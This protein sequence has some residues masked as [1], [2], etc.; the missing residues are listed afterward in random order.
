MEK[1]AQDARDR[2]GRAETA[3]AGFPP[4]VFL[5][6]AQKSGTT[7]LAQLLDMHPRVS[8]A[9][10]K[11]PM[12]FSHHFRKGAEWYREQFAGDEQVIW[13]DASP[14]Y[15]LA[16]LRDPPPGDPYRAV[17]GCLKSLAPDARF[18]YLLRD[19]VERTYSGYWHAVRHGVEK[20]PF[21]DACMD[22][23]EAYL[24]GSDYAGQL[25]LW[26]QHFPLASFLLVDFAELKASPKRVVERCVAFMGLERDTEVPTDVVR[27]AGGRVGWVGQR[28]NRIMIR[29]PAVRRLK[30][31]L[32]MSI[33]NR[34]KATTAGDREIPPMEEADREFLAEYFQ[35][36][37]RRLEELTGFSVGSWT[38]PSRE[39][40]Q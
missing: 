37:N 4:S 20:R 38:A 24:D 25:E 17:P 11:E 28:M 18:I 5:L 34:I 7:T 31:L 8:V 21:A 29:Y 19:P 23:R 35:E 10:R 14:T 2:P 16:P 1:T 9:T 32:P 22:P 26:L 33:V 6:G 15:T 27:N 36:R 3:R 13:L 40:P 39:A 12:Y 30:V